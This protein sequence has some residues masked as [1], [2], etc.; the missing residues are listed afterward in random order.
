MIFDAVIF[1]WGIFDTDY[2]VNI[3]ELVAIYD[4]SPLL[5]VAISDTAEPEL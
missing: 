5:G 1:D 3:I 4:N 2:S